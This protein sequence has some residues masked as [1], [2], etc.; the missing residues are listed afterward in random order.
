VGELAKIASV[1]IDKMMNPPSKKINWLTELVFVF[2]ILIILT[3]AL[4]LSSLLAGILGINSG[5]TLVWMGTV[6]LVYGLRYLALPLGL[7]DL[8]IVVF[9]LPGRPTKTKRIALITGICGVM[10]GLAVWVLVIFEL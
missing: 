7:L 2:N 4:A 8:I 10:A 3:L 6:S 5:S 9:F 1:H